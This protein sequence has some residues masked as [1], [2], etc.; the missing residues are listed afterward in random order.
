MQPITELLCRTICTLSLGV[1]R[2]KYITY[3][4]MYMVYMYMYTHFKLPG[5]IFIREGPPF[6]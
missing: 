6:D 3:M 5:S 4:Y 1:S 2:S